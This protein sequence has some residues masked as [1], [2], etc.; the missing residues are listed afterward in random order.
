MH[1]TG[2]TNYMNENMLTSQYMINLNF[3]MASVVNSEKAIIFNLGSG[4]GKPKKSWW[5]LSY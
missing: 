5:A 1:N 4:E 3:S 2:T